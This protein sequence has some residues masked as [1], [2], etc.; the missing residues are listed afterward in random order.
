MNINPLFVYAASRL[1]IGEE[2]NL[3][4]KNYKITL[5]VLKDPYS[6]AMFISHYNPLQ[7]L[8]N[9]DITNES[10]L[11][12]AWWLDHPNLSLSIIF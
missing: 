6:T 12:N 2:V 4:F 7:N 11:P 1:S 10:I 5:K 8:P 3:D 9:S